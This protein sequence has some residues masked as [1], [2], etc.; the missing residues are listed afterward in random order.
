MAVSY[1]H[2]IAVPDDQSVRA[3]LAIMLQ[4]QIV[5][6]LADPFLLLPLLGHVMIGRIYPAI[7][8]LI[9]YL[10]LIHISSM[11]PSAR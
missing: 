2:L 1:T 5:I 3:R 7:A 4:N 10:S 6:L 8:A 11:V 9:L